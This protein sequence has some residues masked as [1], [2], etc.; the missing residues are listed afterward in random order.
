M[1]PAKQ[2]SNGLGRKA[3][4]FL[5]ATVV[6]LIGLV[7]LSV[8]RIES[9]ARADREGDGGS[10]ATAAPSCWAIKR[11]DPKAK[12]GPYWLLTRTMEVPRRFYCDM[13]TDGGGWVLVGRGRAEWSFHSDGQRS[14]SDL[15]DHPEGIE[16][17]PPAALSTEI[18]NSLLDG[19]AVHEL[20]DGIRLRRAADEQGRSWQE[21]RWFPSDL[22][23]WS[24]AFG[25]RIR[26]D[27]T[28]VDGTSY[29][30]GNTGDS[31]ENG[32]GQQP[33][34]LTGV[35]DERRVFTW[36]WQEHRFFAGFG[37]G[38]VTGGSS[39][40]T[41]FWWQLGS[42]S[43]PL[44][45]TQVWLRPRIGSFDGEAL[46]PQGLGVETNP[47]LLSTVADPL[48]FGVSGVDH[49]SEQF[50][51]PWKVSVMA[52][53][54]VGDSML[55]GGRFTEVVEGE[56]SAPVEQR[57]LA[58]IDIETGAW[59]EKFRPVV[60][61]R[62][63]DI[64]AVGT[65]KA[66]IAGD[67]TSVNKAP[68]TAGLALL[69]L[70]DGTVDPSFGATIGSEQPL[71]A[72]V[73]SIEVAEGW[74]YAVGNFTKIAG[75]VPP[76][77]AAAFVPVERAAKL[78]L[79]GGAIDTAWKPRFTSTVMTIAL[80]KDATRAYVGG[81]FNAVN[82]DPGY[83]SFAAVDTIR[84]DLV[85]GLAPFVRVVDESVQFSQRQAI[86]EVGD[87]L[88]IGGSEHD[89]QMYDRSSMSFL[90]G[91]IMLRGG[92]LQALEQVGGLVYGSCHCGDNLFSDARTFPSPAGFSRVD[93]IS[94]IGAFTPDRLEYVQLWQPQLRAEGG[95]GPWDLE[96]DSRSCLWA[97]GDLV[98]SS[99]VWVGNVARFCPVDVKAPAPPRDLEVAEDEGD[100][101]VSWSGAERA[102]EEGAGGDADAD[103]RYWVYRDDR[104]IAVTDELR[105]FDRSP[106]GSH[107]YFVRA[108]DRSGNKSAT[109]AGVAVLDE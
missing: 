73:R 55:V 26:L 68:N 94:F 58:K 1:V 18:V 59:D 35:V 107:T 102:S 93:P 108:V 10:A 60:E 71:P 27:R 78:N 86:L 3:L 97:G 5:V 90:R 99:S 6:A 21:I 106:S 83:R 76:G 65:D 28:V 48:P 40:P 67:F 54:P 4:A 63:W 17:F 19:Q 7:L 72:A 75:S 45:F 82:G 95:D 50:T 69:N 22:T 57:S 84:G 62:V 33:T 12:T 34:K 39:S 66:L 51:E 61:G 41:S 89:I 98:A 16:A 91:H 88:V 42:E 81:T 14:P 30:G 100:R 70:V 74:I 20:D 25:G 52:L 8:V 79:A 77:Q 38:E 104:V 85:P 44:A 64:A 32:Y 2:R 24:W 92:D 103:V 105:Y 109:T 56:D 15:V 37:T 31:S 49:T 80:S 46:P 23:V 53:E 9:S 87:H 13:E 43:N 11:A 36:R 29:E 101:L 96:G 47:A